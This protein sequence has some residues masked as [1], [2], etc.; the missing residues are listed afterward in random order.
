MITVLTGDNLGV[1]GAVMAL[2]LGSSAVAQLAGRC[3]ESLRAQSAGLTVMICGVVTLIIA[4]RGRSLPILLI[5]AVLAGIGQGLAF[6][7]SLGDV[8]EIAPED[9]K[10]DIVASSHP[11]RSSR[12]RSISRTPP[13]RVRRASRHQHQLLCSAPGTKSSR[14]EADATS[15]R[16][17][18]RGSNSSIINPTKGGFMESVLLN[19]AGHRRCPATTEAD[20]RATRASSTRPIHQRLRRSSP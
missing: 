17:R 12:T 4:V 15:R 13:L 7:G 16:S 2:M 5:G 8:S 18:R 6:M 1:A 3:L 14:S 9:R 20:H 19:V 11:R 10:G